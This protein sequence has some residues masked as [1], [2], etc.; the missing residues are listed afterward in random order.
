MV[1]IRTMADRSDIH[2]CPMNGTWRKVT[3]M[4]Y[5]RSEHFNPALCGQGFL[6][7]TLIEYAN[8]SEKETCPGSLCPEIG[9]A[10]GA[11][12]EDSHP[13]GCYR[14]RLL[15]SNALLIA[16]IDLIDENVAENSK[17]GE[18]GASQERCLRANPIPEAAGDHT[19]SEQGEPR[20]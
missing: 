5:V 10:N 15:C 2:Q 9:F 18:C 14:Y 16:R 3:S 13:S 17:C 7:L 12:Q 20:E 1:T 6:C 4:M 8:Y 19:G 11:W